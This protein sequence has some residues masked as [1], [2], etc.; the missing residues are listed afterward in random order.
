MYSL[1]F[2]V[3]IRHVQKILPFFFFLSAGYWPSLS[4]RLPSASQPLPRSCKSRAWEEQWHEGV[5]VMS[6]GASPVPESLQT[7]AGRLAFVIPQQLAVSLLKPLCKRGRKT[8]LDLLMIFM[9]KFLG[10][11]DFS[12]L[13]ISLEC[14]LMLVWG[15][16]SWYVHLN[17][18][19][20][21]YLGVNWGV[22]Y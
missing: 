12:L 16:G 3:L 15:F 9:W 20:D 7:A 21:C 13:S 1:R 10:K 5:G 22:S 11:L 2:P 17:W 14:V 8:V 6:V 4:S 19:S 18:M